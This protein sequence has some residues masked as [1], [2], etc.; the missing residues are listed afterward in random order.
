MTVPVRCKCGQAYMCPDV[1]NDD[2]MLGAPSCPYCRA[3]WYKERLRE[4][5]VLHVGSD[6]VLVFA[7]EGQVPHYA[8]EELLDR[9]KEW[10]PEV[11]VLFLTHGVKPMVLTTDD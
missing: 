5:I 10:R 11:R 3:E 4:S 7:C 1:P 6:D 2:M 9:V 8:R